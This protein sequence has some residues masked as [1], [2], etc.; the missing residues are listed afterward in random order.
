MEAFYIIELLTSWFSEAFSDPD[1]IFAQILGFIPMFIAFLIFIFHD[2][3]KV[4]F[5]KT[6]S[7]VLWSAHY[8]LLGEFSGGIICS[9]CV[10]RNIIF[11]QKPRWKWVS[12]PAVPAVACVIFMAGT[13]LSRD[14]VKSLLPLTGTCLAVLGFWC[15]DV[16]NI[17]KFNF[18]ATLLWLIY[19]ILVGSVSSII[20]D[21]VTLT[22]I[23]I[24]E[25]RWHQMQKPCE[26][27]EG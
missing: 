13:A 5:F 1:R 12:H 14:G 22:S 11:S 15:T 27:T 24:A 7:D 17:R 9:L 26:A 4:F 19:A 23:V 16:R 8:C 25:C 3:R 2:R 20:C 6:T 10:V 18:P 21:V